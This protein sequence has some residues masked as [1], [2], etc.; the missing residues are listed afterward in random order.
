[1]LVEKGDS[2]TRP[3]VS[4]RQRFLAG[5]WFVVASAIPAVI[6][7]VFFDIHFAIGTGG[8]RCVHSLLFRYSLFLL[9]P[10][11]AAGACGFTFGAVIFDPV[12]IATAARAF[13]Q[14]MAVALVSYILF[15]LAFSVSFS[16]GES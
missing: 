2:W 9:L 12:F 16:V 13:V 15:A 7:L 11:L 5:V 10:V 1:M 4:R 8:G 3:E 14:G 6:A